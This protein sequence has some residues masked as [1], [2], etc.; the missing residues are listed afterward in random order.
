MVIAENEIEDQKEASAPK[1]PWKT[2]VTD[3]NGTD[4]PVVMGKESW[5]PLSDAQRPKNSETASKPEDMA[6]GGEVTSRPPLVQVRLLSLYRTMP[7]DMS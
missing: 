2:P 6:T 3:G 4:V 5:P 1:S 7:S